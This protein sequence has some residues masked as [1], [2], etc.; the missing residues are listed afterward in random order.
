MKWLRVD[1]G[2]RYR[3]ARVEVLTPASSSVTRASVAA[4]NGVTVH[5][6]NQITWGDD[7]PEHRDM[8]NFIGPDPTTQDLSQCGGALRSG[9]ASAAPHEW[10]GPGL[11]EVGAAPLPGDHQWCAYL[12]GPGS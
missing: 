10:T 6:A 2:R 3:V 8:Y 5:V 12:S 7:L 9:F 1:L 11:P 4:L